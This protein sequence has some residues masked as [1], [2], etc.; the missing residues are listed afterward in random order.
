MRVCVSA[1]DKGAAAASLFGFVTTTW[2]TSRPSEQAV[3]TTSRRSQ[4]EVSSG[5]VR[6]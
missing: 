2:L 1:H 3:P 4:P 6:R 5:K